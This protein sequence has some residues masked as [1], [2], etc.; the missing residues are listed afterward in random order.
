MSLDGSSHGG[1]GE[2]TGTAYIDMYS[3]DMINVK[4]SV[5]A[6]A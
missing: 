4:N 1:R 6:E 2:D 5:D 3:P